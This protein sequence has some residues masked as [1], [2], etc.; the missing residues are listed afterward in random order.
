MTSRS[1]EAKRMKG[2]GYEPVL[3]E[4]A[5]VSSETTRKPHRATQKAKLKDLVRYNLQS[6]R[7]YLLKEDFQQLWNYESTTWA[8]QVRQLDHW[9]RQV[10]RSRDRTD[11]E[12]CQNF[13]LH[14]DLHPQLFSRSE[15]VLQWCNRG[16]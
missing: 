12:S 8:A 9:C 7:G 2:D 16:S 14:R 13:T 11:E 3:N 15:R 1:A 5:L 10:M 4:V 6:V